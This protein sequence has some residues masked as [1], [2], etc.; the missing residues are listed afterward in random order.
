[1]DDTGRQAQFVGKVISEKLLTF[2]RWIFFR[3]RIDERI[4]RKGAKRFDP[5]RD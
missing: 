3:L 5:R 1:L 2:T 4:A